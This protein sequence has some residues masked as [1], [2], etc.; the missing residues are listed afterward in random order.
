MCMRMCMCI[1]MLLPLLPYAAVMT[2]N[3]IDFSFLFLFFFFFCF[4]VYVHVHVYVYVLAEGVCVLDICQI[5]VSAW[6]E[7]NQKHAFGV[8]LDGA[9]L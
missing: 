7:H 3:G 2:P 8:L 9:A 5:H 4:Y 6:I 1:C